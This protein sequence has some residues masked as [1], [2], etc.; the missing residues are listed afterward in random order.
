ME[1]QPAL[2]SLAGL[3][4][5]PSESSE[6]DLAGEILRQA[7]EGV[8]K[9]LKIEL[10]FVFGCFYSPVIILGFMSGLLD[11]FMQL[12]HQLLLSSRCHQRLPGE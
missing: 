12:R 6:S 3:E 1:A 8:A 10:S 7:E 2:S 11:S 5:P 9:V 4:T